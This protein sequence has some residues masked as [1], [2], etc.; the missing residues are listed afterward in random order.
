LTRTGSTARGVGVAAWVV[1]A[2]V[3]A[4][5]VGAAAGGVWVGAV[6]ASGEARAA[7]GIL[8][9]VGGG[10]RVKVGSKTGL[11]VAVSTAMSVPEAPHEIIITADISA[12]HRIAMLLNVQASDALFPRPWPETDT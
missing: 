12:I 7:V 5:S 11:E 3:A 9:G 8:V 2:V 1:G 6:V 10:V 4:G